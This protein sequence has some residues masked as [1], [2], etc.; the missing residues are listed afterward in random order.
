[1]FY[2][3]IDSHQDEI[4]KNINET[5]APVSEESEVNQFEED[6]LEEYNI[7][8]N[9]IKADD[10]NN[11]HTNIQVEEEDILIYLDKLFYDFKAN[12][13]NQLCSI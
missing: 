8:E 11:N 4:D 12:I 10:T 2:L 3:E 1:M 7:E 6:Y 13:K 5:I 9:N